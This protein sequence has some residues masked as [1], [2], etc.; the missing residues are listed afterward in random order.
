[1]QPPLMVVTAGPMGVSRRVNLGSILRWPLFDIMLGRRTPLPLM[2]NHARDIEVIGKLGVIVLLFMIALD[3]QA[4]R[5]PAQR[6]I[7]LGFASVDSG[8]R[9]RPVTL[10]C[11]R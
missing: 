6:T 3:T 2:T 8:W 10:R 11:R 9:S 1:M 5:L 7:L 4:Q